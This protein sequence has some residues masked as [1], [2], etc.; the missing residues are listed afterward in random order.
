MTSAS[1]SL[2]RGYS[3]LQHLAFVCLGLLTLATPVL[4]VSFGAAQIGVAEVLEV[5]LADR[6]SVV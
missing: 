2:G 5:L 4:A 1:L 6:K 3:S